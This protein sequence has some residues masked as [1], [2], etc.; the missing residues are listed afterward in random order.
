[1]R[2]AHI[3]IR[4]VLV[5]TFHLATRRSAACPPVLDFLVPARASS[6]TRPF[7]SGK[8][9]QA[10][11]QFSSRPPSFSKSSKAPFDLRIPLPELNRRG[12]IEAW[13]AAIDRFLPPH[14]QSSPA[15]RPD[16][17]HSVTALDLSWALNAAQNASHN[18]LSHLGLTQ[19]RWDS[20]IW[21]VKKLAEDGKHSGD[22]PVQL[23][24]FANV[25]WLKTETRTL[26][27]LTNSP[28]LTHRVRP[29]RRLKHTLDDLT[30]RPDSIDL[31]QTT[32][33]G[34]LGQVWRSLGTMI[35]AAVESDKT[36]EGVIMGHVLEIIAHLHHTGLIP[37]SIY[38]FRQ[39][40]GDY[41]LQQPPTLHLLS[42]EILTALS[43]AT[44]RA[45]EA[46][47]RVAKE[48]MNA[49]YF[50][51]HEIP[52]SR[53]KLQVQNV[54]PELWL[55]LVL[56][57]CLH[58]GWMT[59]GAAILE[60]MASGQGGQRWGLISWRELLQAKV[61]GPAVS[62]QSWRLFPKEEAVATAE[63]RARTRRTISSEIV[64]A[65][66]DGLTNTMRV[67][68]GARGTDPEVLVNRIKKLK[69]FLDLN[70]LSLGSATWD[71]I[72]S[73]LLDSGGVVPEKRPELLLSILDLASGF[74]AEI[75]AP[76][77]T[78]R[79]IVVGSEPPYFFE[80]STVTIGMLHRTMRSFVTN[81]DISGAM[82]TLQMLQQYTDTNKQISL[83]QFFESLKS[84]P[85]RSN[86]PFTST[87]PPIDFPAFDSQVPVVLLAKLLRLVTAAKLYDLGR[88]LLQSEELDGPLIR[89]DMYTHSAMAAA[90]VRYGTLAGENKL[91]MKI[92]KATAFWNSKQLTQYMPTQLFTALLSSQVQL[93][94][95]ESVRSM[96]NYVLE[97]PGYQPQAEVLANFAAGLLRLSGRTDEPT[98]IQKD[99]AR[100][101][102]TGLLFA[103]E[104]LIL[105]R[106][107]NELYC[108]LGIMST[109][110]DEWRQF[111][112]QFLTFST[113]QGIKLTTDD[114]NQILA[115]VL[116]GFGSSK[117]KEM[118]DTWC[119]KPPRT[120]EP[121]RAAGGLPTMPRTRVG[122]GEEHE[123]RP[124]HIEIVQQS[125]AKLILMGRVYPNR[126]TVWS[127]LRRVQLE[128]DQRRHDGKPLTEAKDLEV[129]DTLKWAARLLYYLGF[130][131]ED[132]IRDLGSLST[133]ADLQAPPSPSVVGLAGEE[134]GRP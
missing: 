38:A 103:W 36:K 27:D 10:E 9:H 39:L 94:R 58:G 123:R 90:I 13:L 107:R 17:S 89:R 114:F 18:L 71:S 87:L 7:S 76:N 21:I 81:G 49:S 28:L 11:L 59:D 43:D 127:I 29:S 5:Q 105:I 113:Q 82:A 121:Y 67:G 3:C 45:H 44:W 86:Q 122:K 111:C 35:L 132:I 88:W 128:E 92:V 54:A 77:T 34:A 46:T 85:V 37:N 110:D 106:L 124:D 33:R 51:G 72:I 12:D 75:N 40:R 133:L 2:A 56:W 109:I 62:P 131:Y 74:G 6:S 66:I 108:I 83:Q 65:V 95:W 99:K 30:S 70:S 47:V 4:S 102:F 73:R 61:Q 120:F 22:S 15:N 42:S 41:A 84:M 50:L 98:S 112:S 19:G 97:R 117:G 101:V 130:D 126:Q 118:V 104:G 8:R 20:V 69:R 119:Y 14:I 31:R 52:G 26:E 16:I 24:P 134:V 68:V 80:P 91:V 125:G 115:G 25:I 93:Q 53:I 57:S 79:T 129:R 63:D 60:Q 32:V 96:Q 116:E 55:E 100:E 48:R 78:S 23:E 1:M 64:V